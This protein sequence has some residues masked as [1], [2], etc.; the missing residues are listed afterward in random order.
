MNRVT[1]ITAA[2][3]TLQITV[4]SFGD[5]TPA[6]LPE[7]TIEHQDMTR[8]PAGEFIM[9]S[10]K[11]DTEMLQQRFGLYD[12]PYV[13]E[14]PE[15]KVYLGEYYIDTYEVTNKEY[16]A[17]VDYL[18]KS[19]SRM[20]VANM[21]PITWKNGV[22]PEDNDNLPVV[23]ISWNSARMFCTWGGKRLPTEA[24]WEKAARGTDGRE[25]PWGDEFDETKTNSMGTHGG[26]VP[27]GQFEGDV[28][29]YGV[30]DMAGNVSEW[31]NDWYESYPGNDFQSNYFGERFKVIRGWFWGGIGHYV[32]EMFY[33]S[34]SREYAKPDSLLDGVGYR[35]AYSKTP[36]SQSN[37][38]MAQPHQ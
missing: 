36:G 38:P 34:A 12:I 8:I 14:H 23:G 31:V 7:T 6:E 13:D 18:K 21:T 25:F 22:Y 17:F 27:V 32:M 19:H 11:V 16:K 20:P 26:R 3:L 33:R 2:F 9:G 28:S 15:R 1:Q 10:D 35:C 24:E 37:K 5:A 29:P 30:H 4:P